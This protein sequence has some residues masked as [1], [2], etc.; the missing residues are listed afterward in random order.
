MFMKIREE[1][2][3]HSDCILWGNRV[4][5]PEKMRSYILEELHRNHDGIVISKALARSYFWWPCMD[6]QIEEMIKNCNICSENR[7][8]PAPVTHQW[9]KPDKAWSRVHVDY[10]GPFQDAYSKW[11]EVKIVNDLSSATLIRELRYIFAEQGLPDSIVSDNGRSFISEEFQKYLKSCGIR[12]ILVPPYHPSSNGQAE[13]TVQTVKNKLRK[14]TSEP[15]HVR[16]PN[17]LY[18]LRATPNSVNEKTPAELL[19]N[20]RFRTQFDYL[21]P[22]SYK[23]DRKLSANENNEKLKVR[24]FEI[25]ESVYVRNYSKGPRWLR[26]MVE[27]R[28]GV[29][30]YLVRWNGRLLLRH[31]NQM[32]K[33]GI[34]I[35]GDS[36]KNTSRP[37]ATQY[38]SD[39][40][41][42]VVIPSPEKW[43]DIIGVS[44]P[45]DIVMPG[46]SGEI[47]RTKRALSLS[48]PTLSSKTRITH[49]ERHLEEAQAH[50]ESMLEHKW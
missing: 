27:K 26:G 9:L 10:A 37:D 13:R 47:L 31:I 17:L 18:G 6:K 33:G 3:V 42:H 30:R 36:L 40:E 4:V 41:S 20:R 28:V 21:N 49:L 8:M 44:G 46:S 2:S 14:R 38:N 45:Q 12:Q 19:N 32:H 15:W 34:T 50:S 7:N 16:L 35:N 1:L 25:G 29:C 24:S 23:T 11:P 48:P 43:A 5:V 22:L 39:D